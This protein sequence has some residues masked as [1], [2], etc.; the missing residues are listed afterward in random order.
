MTVHNMSIREGSYH[1]NNDHGNLTK[2]DNGPNNSIFRKP[3]PHKSR[4]IK[5][6]NMNLPCYLMTSGLC[7]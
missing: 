5:T 4:E 1:F 3:E 7:K 2:D 6:K